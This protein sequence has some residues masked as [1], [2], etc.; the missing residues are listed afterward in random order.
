MRAGEQVRSYFTSSSSEKEERAL[1]KAATDINECV[2]AEL[3]KLRTLDADMVESALPLLERA[4]NYV[5][6]RRLSR[7][8]DSLPFCSAHTPPRPISANTHTHT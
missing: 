1:Q 4:V 8:F 7:P 2:L 5:E 3:R 6:V